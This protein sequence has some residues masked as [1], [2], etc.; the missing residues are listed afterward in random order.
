MY[1]LSDE[2][3]RN[4]K[5]SREDKRRS[6]EESESSG[7]YSYNIKPSPTP[8]EINIKPHTKAYLSQAVI[9]VK[10]SSR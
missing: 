9:P 1:T 7:I 6:I 8:I 5:D 3:L 4:P 2:E 10:F